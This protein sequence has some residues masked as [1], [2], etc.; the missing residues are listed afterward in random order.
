VCFLLLAAY[1]YARFGNPLEYG[2]KY[3]LAHSYNYIGHW[4]E[5]GYVPPGL[6]SYLIAPPR[7][8]AL[9]PFFTLVA[10][11]ISYPLGLPLHYLSLSEETGGLF[12]MSPIAIFLVALPWVW[13]RRP[14]MLGPLGLPVMVM[15]GAGALCL[16]LLCYELF[17]TTERYVVDYTTLLLFG[18]LAV[19]LAL[20]AKA[21]GRGRQLI[22]FG[23]GLLAAWSCITGVASVCHELE[24][25]PKLWRGLVNLGS[26]LS[27]AMAAVAGHPVLAEVA[28]PNILSSSPGSYS[29]TATDVSAFWLSAHD[30]VKFTIVSPGSREGYLIGDVVAGPALRPGASL[31]ASL[32]GSVDAGLR[33]KLPLGGELRLQVHLNGG[34]NRLVLRPIVPVVDRSVTSQSEPESH[35]LVAITN[36]SLVD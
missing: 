34:V 10:P 16:L 6:W 23:G 1:D 2:T 11:Q 9:F 14:D 7:L 33:F 36:L 24:T 19:W 26:P 17:D 35:A 12:A 32:D 29:S 18:A 30:Q 20:S 5:L 8:T 25:D 13:R 27:T 28:T 3:Q 4:G 31:E 21:S 22:R 15:V